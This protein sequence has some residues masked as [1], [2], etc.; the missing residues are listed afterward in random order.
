MR[1]LCAF[2]VAL[3]LAGAATGCNHHIAGI[4]DCDACNYSCCGYGLCCPP[5]KPACAAHSL[6]P[7]LA[8][9][10]AAPAAP[11]ATPLPE[12]IKEMH[13]VIEPGKLKETPK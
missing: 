11:V 8:V 12:S 7:A 10:P 3:T 6:P 2:F 1:R 13:K 9:A 4:C 5:Y